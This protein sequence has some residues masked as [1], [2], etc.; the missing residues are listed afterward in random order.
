MRSKSP[1]GTGSGPARADDEPHGGDDTPAS[2][3]PAGQETAAE[4]ISSLSSR[5]QDLLRLLQQELAVRESSPE[6]RNGS[7]P[8]GPPDLAG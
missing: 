3:E 4:S 7:G 8:Y 5:E 1:F 6:R 2:D